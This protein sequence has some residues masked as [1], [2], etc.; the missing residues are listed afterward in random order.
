[1]IDVHVHYYGNQ[2]SEPGKSDKELIDKMNRC[3][4]SLSIVNS[5]TG[6][7]DNDSS[8]G[9]LEVFNLVSSYPKRLLGMA[10]VNPYHRIVAE[11][12]LEK[13]LSVYKFRGLKLHP[14]I[15]GYYAHNKICFKIF[16]ICEHYN[17]PILFHSGTPPYSQ[18][19]QIAYIAEQFSNVKI[20]LGHMGLTYQWREAIELASSY[21]NLF[22]DTCGITYPFAL[23]KAISRVG[24]EKILFATDSPFLEPEMET[25]K[26]RNLKLSSEDWEKIAYKNA[27]LL[28]RINDL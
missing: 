28:F 15:Q 4:I 25:L 7:T 22:L 11:N 23:K 16:E 6:L 3:G 19:G 14:W 8:T 21:E 18:V 9:N 20:I 26:L 27:K 5:L 24:V 17:V 13:C 2:Q 12:E 10:S 1:M